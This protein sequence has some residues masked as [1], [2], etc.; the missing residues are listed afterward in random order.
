MISSS[1]AFF[2]TSEHLVRATRHEPTSARNASGSPGEIARARVADVEQD[3]LV[4]IGHERVDGPAFGP[5]PPEVAVAAAVAGDAHAEPAPSRVAENTGECFVETLAAP[6]REPTVLEQVL[7]RPE[8]SEVPDEGRLEQAAPDEDGA[9]HRDSC[10]EKTGAREREPDR[11][12]PQ[13]CA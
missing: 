9:C 1:D 12:A 5:I 8:A 11:E 7:D 10:D 3:D 4:S 6:D 13:T 2:G